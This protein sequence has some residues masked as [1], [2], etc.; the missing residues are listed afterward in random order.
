MTASFRQSELNNT[1]GGVLT[2]EA[3]YN[4]ISSEK[5][6][7]F[8][9]YKRVFTAADIG[10]AKGQTRDNTDPTQ[11][12]LLM[13][14]KGTKIKAIYAATLFRSVA[15]TGAGNNFERQ[16]F[17]VAP[18]ASP[19]GFKISSDGLSIYV[20]DTGAGTSQILANDFMRFCLDLGNY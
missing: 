5:D 4:L 3:A 13:T 2:P 15:A 10:T 6:S 9:G 1:S 17:G 16:V 8:K 20:F 11:G 18:F 12:C 14:V 19:Y 7:A